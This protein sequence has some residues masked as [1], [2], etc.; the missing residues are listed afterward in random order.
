MGNKEILENMAR[1]IPQL[2]NFHNGENNTHL[3]SNN[4]IN[5]EENFED[6]EEINE[7]IYIGI[8]IRKMKAYKCDLKIDEL[9]KKRDHFW[10]V[11]T[12]HK[13]KNWP[14]W[15]TI[16]RAVL[17]DEFRSSL[18]LEEYKITPING[19]INHLVDS[20]GNH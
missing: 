10:E 7:D 8:G 9:N 14:T 17:F 4:N 20:K 3:S 5:T 1:N 13:T 16:K 11:K 15:N 12:N 19:C 6:M 2:F 18:L